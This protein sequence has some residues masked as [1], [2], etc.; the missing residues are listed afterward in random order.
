LNAPATSNQSSA[1][2]YTITCPVATTTLL[3]GDSIIFGLFRSAASTADTCTD[4]L[5]IQ[6]VQI[7]YQ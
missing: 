1:K 4:N 3:P 6:G 5:F 7:T 2:D